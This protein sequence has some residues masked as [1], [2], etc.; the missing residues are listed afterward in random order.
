MRELK[1]KW[2]EIS[3]YLSVLLIGSIL[4]NC[5]TIY[6]NDKVYKQI[7]NKINV[8]PSLT[9]K[10][11]QILVY[12][13]MTIINQ[14]DLVWFS[15]EDTNSM[16]PTIDMGAFALGIDVENES[17]VNIGD[18]ITYNSDDGEYIIHRVINISDDMNGT[19]YTLKGDN[20]IFVDNDRVRLED[21]VYKVVGVIY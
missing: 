13:D 14:S 3:F 12:E 9:I 6:D 11:E 8:S 15:V 17:Q 10:E 21:I 19:Y 1:N 4:M 2:K 20:N 16:L 7:N 5:I 18:I